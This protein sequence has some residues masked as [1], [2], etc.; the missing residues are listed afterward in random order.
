MRINQRFLAGTGMVALIYAGLATAQA[1]TRGQ[2]TV[3]YWMSAETSAGLGAGMMGGGNPSAAMMNALLGRGG[4][5]ESHAHSLTLQL[6]S[7]QRAAGDPAAEHLVPAGLQAGPSLP[8]AT[9]R[10]PRAPEQPREPWTDGMERPKG[11]ILIYWG[12]GERARAGQP[13]VIDLASLASGRSQSLMRTADVRAA[14]PPAPGRAA[15]YGEW[16]NERSQTRVP[17][18][19]SLVGSHAVRGNYSPEIRFALAQSQDFL[20][21]VQLLS[22][23]AAAS[24]AMPLVWKPVPGA[25][26][27]FASTMG[28]NEAGDMV[29]WSSSETQIFD[30]MMDY[31][32][33]DEVAR[34]VRQRILLPAPADRCTVPAEA[35]QSAPQA[36]LSLTAFGSEANFSHPAR[37]ASAPASWRPEWTVK[38]RTKS[39]YRSMLGMDMSEITGGEDADHP[40]AKAGAEKKKKKL[41]IPVPGIGRVPI[42]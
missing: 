18:G 25:L 28:S 9:P 7:P 30:M 37:P 4:G 27:W 19:G 41:R 14:V 26:G 21:P 20:A 1:Q 3:E 40:E 35:V 24:G 29:M 23:G 34:L 17:A 5:Q 2:G 16:P 38:L 13:V 33:P 15:T 36:M 31:L 6:G 39:T 22:G 42:G 10:A 11:R 32:P 12:C 8:L